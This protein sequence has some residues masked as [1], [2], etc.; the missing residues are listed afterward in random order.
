[1]RKIFLWMVLVP[2]AAL[3]RFTAADALLSAPEPLVGNVGRTERLDLLD[4]QKAGLT[5]RTVSN[6]LGGTARILS[7][8]DDRIDLAPGQAQTVSLVLMPAKNDTLIGVITTLQ[9]P[10]PDSKL[11]IFNRQWQEQPKAW[12]EPARKA[13]GK[14]DAPFLLTEYVLSGDTL[15]L[16]DRTDLWDKDKAPQVRELRYVWLPRKSKFTPTK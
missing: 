16:H 8:S 5:D 1:M 3:A 13:W 11:Q 10:A 7:L 6:R 2:V 12:A 9:T 4:Y 15:T 14:T